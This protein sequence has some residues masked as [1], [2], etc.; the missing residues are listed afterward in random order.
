MQRDVMRCMQREQAEQRVVP[1]GCVTLQWP[2]NGNGAA[3]RPWAN[4][5]LAVTY[6][7]VL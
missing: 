6:R 7:Q 3:D 5:E 4:A 2:T 1:D